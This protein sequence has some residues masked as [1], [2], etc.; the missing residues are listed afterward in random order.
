MF[1]SNCP[2]V[3]WDYAI[4]RRAKI[5]CSTTRSNYLLDGHTPHT[6]LTGQS[7]DIS[8]IM[9]F[10]WYE[11][12]IYRIEGQTYPFQHQKIGRTLRPA[13]RAGNVMSQWVLT[14]GGEIMPRIQTLRGLT[15]SEKSNLSMIKRMNDYDEY[16]LTDLEKVISY[17]YSMKRIL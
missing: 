13:T 3:L 9:D 11:W 14:C 6:K 5:V 15:E 17:Q 12:V 4:E 10:G 2:M 8:N 16:I 1:Q 7:T